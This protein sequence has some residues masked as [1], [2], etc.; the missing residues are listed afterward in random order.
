MSGTQDWASVYCGLLENQIQLLQELES[1]AAGLAGLIDAGD[2]DAMLGLID[3]R[4]VLIDRLSGMQTES[5]A[6]RE[7]YEAS[8]TPHAEIASK[9]RMV[10]DLARRILAGDDRDRRALEA[11]RDA[12]GRELGELVAGRRAASA[13]SQ[14]S[15]QGARFQDQQG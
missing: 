13:Y 12:T 2:G 7:R 3:Q 5:L 10:S 14:R 1:V 9:S 11:R 8:R 4:Q 6:F 15:E